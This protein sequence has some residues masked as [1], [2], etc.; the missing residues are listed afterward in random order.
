MYQVLESFP[1]RPSADKG[2]GGGR[3]AGVA[4]SSHTS[5]PVASLVQVTSEERERERE[6]E[7][8]GEGKGGR[9][10]ERENQPCFESKHCGR[11][12]DSLKWSLSVPHAGHKTGP[13]Q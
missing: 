13:I 4:R 8:E 11:W 6:G 3:G 12:S 10:R 1:P 2:D 7:G 5:D 9:G